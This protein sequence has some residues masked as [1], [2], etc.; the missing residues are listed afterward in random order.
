M[1]RKR[2]KRLTKTYRIVDFLVYRIRCSPYFNQEKVDGLLVSFSF[3]VLLLA[4]SWL[5][6]SSM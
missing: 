2:V 4:L 3:V 6:Y 5:F 1:S